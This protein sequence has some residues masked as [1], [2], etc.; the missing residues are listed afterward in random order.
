MFGKKQF[1][2]YYY[3]L[4]I[5]FFKKNGKLVIISFFA[6]FVGIIGFLSLF[7]YIKEALS[8]EEI[9]GMVGN[10]TVNSP[11]DEIKTKVDINPS[12]KILRGKRI[13]FEM[14]VIR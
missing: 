8:K 4:I 13:I 12:V 10:Y 11:P 5:E 14:G 7:P 6:S 3:W 9:I 2:R 1:F